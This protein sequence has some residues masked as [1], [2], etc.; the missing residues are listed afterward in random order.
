[1][2][3]LMR[4]QCSYDIAQTRLRER[5]IRV[6]RI[7]NLPLKQF[8]ALMRKYRGKVSFAGVEEGT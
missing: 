4:M 2:D 1:M 6:R 8:K 5:Q 7:P 3:M